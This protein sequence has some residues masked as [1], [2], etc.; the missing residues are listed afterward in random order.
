IDPDHETLRRPGGLQG[1]AV[2]E[3][4]LEHAVA[5]R[6]LKPL[7][8]GRVHRGVLPRHQ[9]PREVAEEATRVR[10]LRAPARTH[11]GGSGR[12]GRRTS[13]RLPPPSRAR[14][15][16]SPPWWRAIWRT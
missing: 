10:E 14:A 8:A 7:D 4:D 13:K 16:T 15:C 2:A 12:A 11:V 5:G 3:A 1:A 6:N 9:T